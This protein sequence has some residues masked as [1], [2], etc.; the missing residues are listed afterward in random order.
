LK[1]DAGAN[2][3]IE[4][5]TQYAITVLGLSLAFGRVGVGWEDVQWLAAAM[6]VGLGFGLQEIFAN[7][8]SGLL[9]LFERPIR[10]GDTVTVGDTTGKVTRIRIRATTIVDGDLRELIVPN[11]EFISGKVMNW[12]LTD[13]TSRMTINV[14]V[15][16]GNDPNLVRQVLL[17]VATKH[18]AVL[19]DPPPNALFDEF[20]DDTLKFTLRVFMANRDVYD[21][22]RHDLNAGIDAAFRQAGIDRTDHPT[23]TP[24]SELPHAA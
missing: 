24:V 15:P 18:A 19:K 10:V 20:A 8:A 23:A 7:F 4:A 11:R 21:Q 6:T 16:R 3:A 13:T 9:L 22:L 12:T 17:R 2:F 1:L 5:I 14:S